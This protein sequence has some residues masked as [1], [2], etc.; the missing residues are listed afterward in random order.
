MD[1]PGNLDPQPRL[2]HPS[3]RARSESMTGRVAFAR[4]TPDESRIYAYGDHV[5]NVYR[6]R[7]ILAPDRGYYVVHLYEDPRGPRRV[8]DRRC[9]RDFAQRLFESHPFWP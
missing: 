7:D 8:H 3:E 4:L 9:I 6:H 2:R 5:G 1:T